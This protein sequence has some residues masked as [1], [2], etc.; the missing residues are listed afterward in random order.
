MDYL[1]QQREAEL[2]TPVTIL[3]LYHSQMIPSPHECLNIIKLNK[4]LACTGA[5]MCFGVVSLSRIRVMTK[6]DLKTV[7]GDDASKVE[8]AG[9]TRRVKTR[10]CF[11]KIIQPTGSYEPE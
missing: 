11:R 10:I 7:G 2:I 3:I 4:L 9:K 5:L 1:G 6:Q 8:T